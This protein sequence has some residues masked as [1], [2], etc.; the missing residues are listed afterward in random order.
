[1]AEPV[2]ISFLGGLGEIGR[3]CA[4]LEA[5]GQIVVVD[6]GLMFPDPDMLG[7]DLVLPDLSYLKENA[8]RIAGLV[9]THGHEDHTGALA[10]ALEDLSLDVY[11]SSL[12]IA[13]A[14]Q[15]VSEAGLSSK[16]NWVTVRDGELRRIGP[17]DV[18][19]IPVTHSVPQ[20]FALAFH[21]SQGII[22]HSGD[23]KIDLEPVD[24]RFMDLE[25]IGA[26]ANS[27][28]VRLLLSDSTN[29]DEEGHTDSEASLQGTFQR[30]F[31]THQGKRIIA[32]SFASHIHRL[33]QLVDAAIANGR[34][35]ATLGR[36]MTKNIA[37]AR[38]LGVLHIPDSA[39]IDIEEVEELEPG[40][41]FVLSTGSQGEPMS[42]LALLAAG[43]GK[44][45]H[46]G[47]RDTVVMSAHP[48]PGNEWAVSKVID[49]LCRLGVEVVYGEEAKVHVSGHASEEELKL[50]LQIA[51]PE[52]FIPIHG[53]YRHLVAHSRLAKR[54]G[55][56][57][58]HVFVCED[59][60]VVE[61]TDT[62]LARVG[63]VSAAYLYVDGL[64]SEVGH[65][66][67][68]DRKTLAEEGVL[69]L[70]CS[71]DTATGDVLASPQL[72]TRGWADN[73]QLEELSSD[74]HRLVV[75]SSSK[76]MSD[77]GFDHEVF[78]RDVRSSL[79]KLLMDKLHRRPM[80]VPVIVTA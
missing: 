40:R 66:V 74:V 3:N 51:R 45:L 76:A 35:V 24:G 67:I 6:C 12:T 25:R 26:L 1:M 29:A 5:S 52:F 37:L 38:R 58:D 16:A 60:D 50:M 43:E 11:G 34:L 65:G 64:T 21:T 63:E 8:D 79:S 44:W 32:T 4:C 61:L 55:V 17:F 33:Q 75:T 31:A 28:G 78:R 27:E 46:L 48:V 20:G 72:V 77:G 36:S 73:T 15:R 70:V 80:I 62:G 30:L 18:E 23:F 68:R 47:E 13:L 56:D 49:G 2:R 41:V 53:E 19:F 10:F 7:V 22:L 54:M 9:L 71:I 69:V 14:K 57:E 42:A 59:G 39:L